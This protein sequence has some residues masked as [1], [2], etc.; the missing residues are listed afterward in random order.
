MVGCGAGTRLV[1]HGPHPPH[2]QEFVVVTY[3][4]PPAEIE[5][6][7]PRR[8]DDRCAWVD[9]HYTWDGRRWTWEAGRWVIPPAGC[10]YAPAVVAWSKAGEERLYFTP[11][12]WYPENAATLAE[13]AATCPA[14]APCPN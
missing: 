7:P 1:P 14:P 10:Y 11:P 2:L 6:I 3:P 5:E 8:G 9:G 13:H 12:R 4:P